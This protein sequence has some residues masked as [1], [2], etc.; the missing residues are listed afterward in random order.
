MVKEYTQ[1]KDPYEKEIYKDL[2]I[3]RNI[4]KNENIKRYMKEKTKKYIFIGKMYKIYTD[5]RYVRNENID[6]KK[7]Y[8]KKVDE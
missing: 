1:E 8:Q 3:E 6:G 7:T 2:N 4:Y 5:K